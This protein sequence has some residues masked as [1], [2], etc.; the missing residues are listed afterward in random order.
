MTT[1]IQ[2]DTFMLRYRRE[3]DDNETLQIGILQNIES[4]I[5]DLI[6]LLDSIPVRANEINESLNS[7]EDSINAFDGDQT[8]SCVCK[9]DDVYNLSAER[10]FQDP[11]IEC[12]PC[13]TSACGLWSSWTSCSKS[14]GNGK[15]TRK[16]FWRDHRK[17]NDVETEDCYI[18]KLKL[19]TTGPGIYYIL[20]NTVLILKSVNLEPCTVWGA[21]KPWGPCSR[22]CNDG[23]TI[24]YHERYR[25]MIVD[26]VEDCGTGDGHEYYESRRRQCNKKKTCKAV[27]KWSEWG[28]WSDCNPDCKQ[29]LRLRRRT[30]NENEGAYCVGNTVENDT[31]ENVAAND[32]DA[33]F[34][35]Y[36]KCHKIPVSFCTDLRYADQLKKLCQKRCGCN[37]RKRRTTN[38]QIELFYSIIELQ[39]NDLKII[40][41]LATSD[42]LENSIDNSISIYIQEIPEDELLL[43]S[44]QFFEIADPENELRLRRDTDD[45]DLESMFASVKGQIDEIE[46][47]FQLT[48]STFDS[49]LQRET[50]IISKL[51]S[52]E[53]R[54]NKN[55]E[56][57][58]D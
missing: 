36:D 29:G 28:E 21:W 14:C 35:K 30:N 48:Q 3:K 50:D 10:C 54:F 6:T 16:F 4:Q 7:I 19:Y 25:C 42:I 13:S 9:S 37:A 51:V 31:C 1:L 56:N 58:S 17:S 22:P 57:V 23:E 34:D 47:T 5:P 40:E 41:S 33:C 15:R 26:G 55:N 52:L 11:A 20:H 49:L 44:N 45:E 8:D 27:C 46:T 2:D 12:L 43:N 24:P 38:D 39:Q 32:C 53:I 18:G